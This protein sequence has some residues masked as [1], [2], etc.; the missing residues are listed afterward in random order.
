MSCDIHLYV[1]R[2][3]AAGDWVPVDPPLSGKSG[4]Q[5]LANGTYNHAREMDWEDW[6]LYLESEARDEERLEGRALALLARCADAEPGIPILANS[7]AFGR[8][9]AA[10][11]ELAGVRA[12]SD[13]E[14]PIPPRH[15]PDDISWQ[16]FAEGWQ[17]S[18][19]WHQA[20]DPT[21]E[22]GGQVYYWGPDWHTPHWYSLRELQEHIKDGSF[23]EKR[24]RSLRNAMADVA[25]THSLSHADVR[26][27]FWFDN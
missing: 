23:T 12:A 26:A 1:E 16:L 14:P 9:Y 11:R 5:Y 13:F 20:G 6:G 8:N 7:W 17:D 2:K 25:K 10:F 27:V 15:V 4:P 3:R 24:I 19:R 18:D 22:R 21:A